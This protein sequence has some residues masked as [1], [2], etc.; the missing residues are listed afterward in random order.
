MSHVRARRWIVGVLVVAGLA[1]LALSVRS[2]TSEPQARAS[3]TPPARV[4]PIKGTDLS[5]VTLSARAARRLGIRTAPVQRHTRQQKVIP[6]SAVLYDPH[7][8][9]F[10]YTSPAPLVFVRHSIV[11]ADIDGQRAFLSSGPPVGTA[12]ATVGSQEL[13]GTEY[14]VEED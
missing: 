4:Q 7:G 3:D 11:V 9:T 2:G 12:V 1:A 13:F 14:A 10:T 8:R 5:R 6:Y